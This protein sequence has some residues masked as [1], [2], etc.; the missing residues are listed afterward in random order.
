MYV[1]PCNTMFTGMTQAELVAAL[2]AAQKAYIAVLTG[3]QGVSFAY[4]QGDGA[5][6]VTYKAVDAASLAA[7][8]R[9]L[10]QAAGVVCR[11]RRPVNFVFR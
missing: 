7:L 2:S 8:I 9:Q 5:K 6:S 3:Q 1:A 11:A 10:Q 4:T